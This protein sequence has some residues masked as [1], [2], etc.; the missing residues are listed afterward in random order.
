MVITKIEIVPI[1]QQKGLLAFASVVIDESL[2]LGS[3]GVHSRLDGSG[4]RLSYP[5]KKIGASHL[6]I[7]HPIIHELSKEIEQAVTARAIEL[8]QT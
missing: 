8:F 2:Y 1:Q 3:I 6:Y 5:S 4:Y 7:H